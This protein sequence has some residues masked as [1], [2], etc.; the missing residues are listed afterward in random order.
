VSAAFSR[1]LVS[2]MWEV[3]PT[4]PLT[5]AAVSLLLILVA[6]LAGVAP[7]RRALRVDPTVALKYE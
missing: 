4:D 7:V 6:L 5:Y 1:L 2:L 3:R